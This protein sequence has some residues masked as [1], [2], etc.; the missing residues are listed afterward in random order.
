MSRGW[1]PY[2]KKAEE[3]GLDLYVLLLRCVKGA[4]T[5]AA[6][7]VFDWL[8]E[9]ASGFCHGESVVVLDVAHWVLTLLTYILS[10]CEAMAEAYA[11]I[12]LR[13][14]APRRGQEGYSRGQKG[15]R[16]S[17]V[18]GA[19]AKDK[20]LQRFYKIGEVEAITTLSRATIKRKMREGSFP[21]SVQLS[22]RR[23]GWERSAVDEWCDQAS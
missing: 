23:V 15:R 7:V 14:R 12:A 22:K 1:N 3:L 20:S 18:T 2:L 21:R 17:G 8:I 10:E 11:R 9:F 6:L 19:G 5:L 13:L 4:A 16:N